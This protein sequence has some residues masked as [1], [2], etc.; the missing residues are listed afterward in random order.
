MF[1][2]TAIII[3]CR[4][5]LRSIC[6]ASNDYPHQLR[7]QLDQL[8]SEAL[9]TRAK[10]NSARLRLMRLSEAAEKLKRQAAI[11]VNSGKENEAR[12]L[13]FQKKKVMNAMERSK[14]R[15]ELLD[16]LALK[17]NEAISLKESQ[18]IGN[19]DLDLEVVSKDASGPVR[20]MTP[21]PAVVNDSDEENDHA[22]SLKA[23]LC[24]D[25]L[26]VIVDSNEYEDCSNSLNDGIHG[27]ANILVNKNVGSHSEV[28]SDERGT[29]ADLNVSSYEDF[30][31]H[32]DLQLSKIEAEL[33][34]IL[35][36][37][38]LILNDKE[39]PNNSKVQQTTELLES[40]C[41][42]RQRI[43]RIMQKVEII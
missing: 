20:I 39:K 25:T 22:K 29:V 35:N 38:S 14:S 21:A 2:T 43:D 1:R 41:A 23:S 12:D 7:L 4:P 24:K 32:V 5:P 37:S 30:L 34:T 36:V 15:V 33:V 27:E 6:A 26:S 40:I 16:Q 18:L 19:I 28:I 3:P 11:S 31:E 42:I 13:L 9:D 10:A 17:L 8:H